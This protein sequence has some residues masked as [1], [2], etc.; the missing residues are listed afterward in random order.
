MFSV[1]GRK[2]NSWRGPNDTFKAVGTYRKSSHMQRRL[3]KVINEILSDVH[4]CSIRIVRQTVAPISST[5]CGKFLRRFFRFYWKFVGF[6][7]YVFSHIEI[8]VLMIHFFFN[9]L[10]VLFGT[11]TFK[12]FFSSSS[13]SKI[14]SIRVS[15]WFNSISSSEE[16]IKFWFLVIFFLNRTR[17]W[18][19]FVNVVWTFF[20]AGGS[21][22]N[23][24]AAWRKI[25]VTL[26]ADEGITHF[27]EI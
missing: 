16:Q 26:L 25:V 7:E 21:E 19:L 13:L 20:F 11:Y 2:S 10:F 15:T 4:A 17:R 27:I 3:I 6:F 14:L 24:L 18:F 23:A 12:W 22:H 9:W 1:V 5:N 8:T